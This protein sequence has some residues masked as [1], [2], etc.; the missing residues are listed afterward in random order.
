MLYL[1]IYTACRLVAKVQDAGGV[2]IAS[3]TLKKFKGVPSGASASPMQS[4][5]MRRKSGIFNTNVRKCV[6]WHVVV[7]IVL[8]IVVHLCVVRKPFLCQ[9]L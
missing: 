7:V 9:L 3:E 5:R 1:I 8:V 4:R 6:K 2:H